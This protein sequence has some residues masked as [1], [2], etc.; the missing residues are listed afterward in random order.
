MWRELGGLD[1]RFH[2]LWFEDVDFCLRLKQAGCAIVFEPRCRFRHHGGHSLDSVT[3]ADRQL[4]WYRNLLYYVRKNLGFAAALMMRLMIS[5]GAGG[6]MAAFVVRGDFS[7]AGAF[8]AVI[9]MAWSA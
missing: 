4:F 2:P 6:R 9:R 7:R 8:G 3:F 5:A 1:E